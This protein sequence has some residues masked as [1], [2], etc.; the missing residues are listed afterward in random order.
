METAGMV[1]GQLMPDV[2]VSA[3]HLMGCGHMDCYSKLP[4]V[5]AGGVTRC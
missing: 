5:T 3:S 4:T 1:S 2:K